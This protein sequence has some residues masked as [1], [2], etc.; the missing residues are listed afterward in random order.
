MTAP[1]WPQLVG[2]MRTARVATAR[3]RWRSYDEDDEP[4]LGTFA[5]RAP[6]DWRV[7]D[8]SGLDVGDRGPRQLWRDHEFE[9]G[10][11]YHRA[12]GPAVEVE[13]ARRRCWQVRIE[14]PARKSG[15]LTLVVDDETGLCL[16]MANDDHGMY[17]EVVE[18]ELDV[19]LSGETFAAARD[20]R[21][22]RETMQ[23]RYDLMMTSPPPTP[24][25]FPWRRT[26]VEQPDCLELDTSRGW[27][28][29][30]RA[31]LG[32]EAPVTE[33]VSSDRVVRFDSGEWSWAVACPEPLDEPTARRVV[34]QVVEEP[35]A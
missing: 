32:T 24:C 4:R 5:F 25:W 9:R 35:G 27:A 14:P 23:A 33:F 18:V 13:H 20:E 15:L 11:D 28:T 26:W 31:A 19:E 29:V 1:S 17:I 6:D 8:A 10:D 34:E 3:G 7:L 30:G 12:A 22:E 2:W 21:A 16:R